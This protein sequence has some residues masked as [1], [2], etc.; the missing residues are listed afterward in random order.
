VDRTLEAAGIK[1]RAAIEA[2]LRLMEGGLLAQG[3]AA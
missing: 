1:G 3:K 2:K